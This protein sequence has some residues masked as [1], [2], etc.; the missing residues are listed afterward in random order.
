MTDGPLSP[1]IVVETL[2]VYV[3]GFAY[4]WVLEGSLSLNGARADFGRQVI[5]PR[6]APGPSPELSPK[7]ITAPMEFGAAMML[8]S[9]MAL[10][11]C[12]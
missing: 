4:V 5:A 1:Q 9:G 12:C 10:K 2:T 11:R 6:S 3:P 8:P 7:S